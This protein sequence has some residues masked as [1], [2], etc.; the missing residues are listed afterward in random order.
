MG[1]EAQDQIKI[2]QADF[3]I[4]EITGEVFK[5][6]R[7]GQEVITRHREIPDITVHYVEGRITL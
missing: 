5:E 7:L 4:E 2:I 6:N 1:I 3:Q